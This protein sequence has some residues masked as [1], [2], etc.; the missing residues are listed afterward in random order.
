M[1]CSARSSALLASLLGVAGAWGFVTQMLEID[2]A[3]DPGCWS[4]VIG[5]A[6]AL[7]IAVG[8]LTTW[9]ALSVRPAGFLR[10]E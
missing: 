2:F 10:A 3:A 5:G 6:I 9:S 7:T 4:L 1:A 8:A